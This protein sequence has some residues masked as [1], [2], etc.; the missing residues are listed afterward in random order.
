MNIVDNDKEYSSERKVEGKG[1]GG[2]ECTG[3]VIP[4]N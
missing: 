3:E 2:K 1:K 4:A